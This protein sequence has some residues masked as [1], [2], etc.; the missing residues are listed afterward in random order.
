[1]GG[2]NHFLPERELYKIG[3]RLQTKIF[4]YFV[5][6]KRHRPG[7]DMQRIGGFPHGSTLCQQL[8][9]FP[10]T[11]GQRPGVFELWIP[12]EIFLELV[13]R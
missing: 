8:Q 10:L 11:T 2:L 13:F 6:V 7:S 9:D 12:D 3:V 4:H 1:V 5:F